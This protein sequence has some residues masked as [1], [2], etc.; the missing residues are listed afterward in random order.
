MGYLDEFDD[1]IEG[2]DL[3]QIYLSAEANEFMTCTAEENA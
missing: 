1:L 2:I 3:Y